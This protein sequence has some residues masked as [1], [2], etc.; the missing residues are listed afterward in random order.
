MDKEWNVNKPPIMDGTNYDYW[1]ARM[2]AFLKSLDSKTWKA[3]V[4]GWEHPKVKDKDGK[5]TSELKLEEDW[6]DD[7]DKLALGNS[8]DL[9]ALFNGVDKNVFRVIKS[10]VV[11]K[12]AWEIL[13][14]THEGTSKVKMSKLQL[15]TSK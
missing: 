10:C 12:E 15:L 7:E 13:R 8:K 9:N 5:D 1:K 4:K 11:A 14:T 3:V 6:T 2:V